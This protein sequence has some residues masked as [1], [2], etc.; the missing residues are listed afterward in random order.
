MSSATLYDL[1]TPPP[2]KRM[3]GGW[4]FSLLLHFVVT[5]V[6]ASCFVASAIVQT[7]EE[8]IREVGMVLV[9]RSATDQ[10]EYFDEQDATA[11][12]KDD[13][14]ASNANG[15]PAAVGTPDGLPNQA[16]PVALPALPETTSIAGAGQ[17]VAAPQF[18]NQGKSSVVIL[19]G[20]DDAAILEAEA[21]ARSRVPPKGPTAELSLF[22][23]GNAV[24]NSF[25]F[26]IDRS[27]SMG[28]DG[29][30]A[31]EAA[32]KEFE[33]TLG[34]LSAEQKIQVVAYNEQT[35]FI[36]GRRL[37]EA[38]EQNRLRLIKFVNDLAAFG[39][40]EHEI[41]LVSALSMQPDVVFFFSDGGDPEMNSS[42]IARILKMAA[43]KTAIHSVQFG[44]DEEPKENFMKTLATA[45]RGSYVYI[46]VR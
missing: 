41:A 11:A 21:Q 34:A 19:P 1:E 42:Q 3:A 12:A 9:Q 4:V 20:I 10:V 35:V 39:P 36:D 37:L 44:Y 38:S 27:K 14:L 32:G 46:R 22:G 18:G 45:T 6:A 13:A 29:L 25:V 30:G 8:P 31:I 26:V 16:P 17:L 33:K 23:G 5:I 40:T 43:G 2:W 15:A 7:D 24:G 28:G